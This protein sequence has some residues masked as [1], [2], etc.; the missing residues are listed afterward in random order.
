MVVAAPA[1][2]SGEVSNRDMTCNDTQLLATPEFSSL[3]QTLVFGY[4]YSEKF[5]G[6]NPYYV[7]TNKYLANTGAAIGNILLYIKGYN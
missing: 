6:S 2:A 5:E 3:T 1:T 4:G 7:R